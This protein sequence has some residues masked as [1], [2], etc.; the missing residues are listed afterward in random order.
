MTLPDTTAT[1]PAAPLAVIILAAGQGTR[2]KSATH[3]VLHPIAGKP[4]LLHLLDTIAALS[5]AREIVVVGQGREQVEAAVTPHGI[6][7]ALQ[8]DQLGTAHAVAQALPALDGFDGKVLILYGDTPFVGADTLRNMV[9]RL[10]APD[11]PGIVVLTHTP[12]DAGA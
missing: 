9:A 12:P 4:M 11:A 1:P 10:G 3:K 8:A 7:T 5:P 6:A 2:M